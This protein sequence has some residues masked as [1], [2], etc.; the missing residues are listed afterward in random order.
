MKCVIF[1]SMLCM[2]DPDQEEP[3]CPIHNI[4]MEIIELFT[5]PI[6]SQGEHAEAMTGS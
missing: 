6:S 5:I 2:N 3:P 4:I 1:F